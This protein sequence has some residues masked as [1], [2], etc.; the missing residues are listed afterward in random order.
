MKK[1]YLKDLT[2]EEVIRRL[3]AGE[4]LREDDSK[5]KIKL[6]EGMICSYFSNGS[7]LI[8]DSVLFDDNTKEDFYFET[9]DK[10]KL[11]VG[12]CYK[13]RSG[14]KAFICHKVNESD[15]FVGTVAGERNNGFLQEWDIHG[16]KDMDDNDLDLISEWS[17]D[18]EK[19]ND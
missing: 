4:V 9:T 11:E 10:L 19:E 18:E 13:T 1:T 2:P 5:I 7:V 14:K 15:C 17:D 12:K 16:N 3:Q 8:N 6:V